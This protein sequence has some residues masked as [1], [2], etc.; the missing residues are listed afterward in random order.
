MAAT[1]YLVK[2][3][4]SQVWHKFHTPMGV[5]EFVNDSGETC[6]IM[7]I[8]AEEEFDAALILHCSQAEGGPKC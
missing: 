1:Q 5:V 3:G 7:R 6:K 8:I 4:E 2:V